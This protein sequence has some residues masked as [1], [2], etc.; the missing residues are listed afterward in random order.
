[1]SNI[2]TP[3]PKYDS[4]WEL[5]TQRLY[6]FFIGPM[7]LVLMLLGVLNDTQGRTL[8]FNLAYLVGLACLP[9]SRW[10]EM[11][12]GRAQTAEGRPATWADFRSY[13]LTAV[14]A[15]LTALVLANLWITFAR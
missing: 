10:L 3:E 14:A 9:L 4:L 15:G 5:L 2:Q 11:R 13:S 8:V 1:M 6:W 7:F 12:T